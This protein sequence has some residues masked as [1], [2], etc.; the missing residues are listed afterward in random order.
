VTSKTRCEDVTT[1]GCF[2]CRKK[3]KPC[4]LVS[5]TPPVD[6]EVLTQL[7]DRLQQQEARSA[8]LEARLAQLESGSVSAVTSTPGRKTCNPYVREFRPTVPPAFDESIYS[9]SGAAD[10]PDVMA[11]GMMRGDQAER[12]LQL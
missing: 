5:T 4:S 12:A 1:A 11:R 2:L 7:V 9:H 6:A 8:A 3:Q 10:F